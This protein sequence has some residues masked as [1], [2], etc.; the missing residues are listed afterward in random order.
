MADVELSELRDGGDGDDIV[1]GQ[2]VT[3]VRLDAILR[4][5]AFLD[6]S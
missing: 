3:R 4:G 5:E 2:A 1:V 6:L